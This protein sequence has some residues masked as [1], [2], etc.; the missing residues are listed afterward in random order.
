M[1]PLQGWDLLVIF[2]WGGARRLANPRLGIVSPLRGILLTI[3]ILL[4]Q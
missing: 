4:N 3:E 1:Q 2:P